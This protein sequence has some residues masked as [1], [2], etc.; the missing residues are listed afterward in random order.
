MFAIRC[1]A[2]G[3][4]DMEKEQRQNRDK[5]YGADAVFVIGFERKY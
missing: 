3:R 2:P 4:G 1:V 5:V